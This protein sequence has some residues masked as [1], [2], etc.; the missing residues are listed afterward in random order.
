MAGSSY[1]G[2]PL[3][4][5]NPALY[6]LG[7]YLSG[8]GFGNPG[9][10]NVNYLSSQVQPVPT[11]AGQEL[12]QFGGQQNALYNLGNQAVSNTQAAIAPA[13]SAANS[14]SGL[15]NTAQNQ[16]AGNQAYANQALQTGFDPMQS[17]YN[18]Y[19]NQLTDATNSQEAARGIANTP[20][21][22]AVT[23]DTLA[24][25]SN[26]WAMNN[27]QRQ[28]LGA[29]TATSLQNQQLSSQNL[30][31]QLFDASGNLDLNAAATMLQSYGLQGQ[32]MQAALSDLV[33][34]FGAQRVQQSVSFG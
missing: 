31:G 12:Q 6:A 30:A 3:T 8:G 22:A 23:G 17:Q 1:T 11:V 5:T 9:A 27:A 13:Q 21:G 33:N 18:F 4:Q 25:F 28:A 32:N 7:G 10:M 24:N 29:Q 16:F 19:A 34:M 2:V 15:A 26:Q 14:L 20:Y